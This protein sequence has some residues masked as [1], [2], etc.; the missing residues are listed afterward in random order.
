MSR[1]CKWFEVCPLKRFYEEGKLEKKWI[2]NYCKGNYK[3][4]VRYKMEEQG[5]IHPD[6]MLPNGEIKDDLA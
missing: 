6:N 3:S 5:I 1:S 2:K 4:C